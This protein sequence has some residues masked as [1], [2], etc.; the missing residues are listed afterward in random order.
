MSHYFQLYGLNKS[1]F[2]VNLRRELDKL[3]T[4]NNVDLSGWKHMDIN[5][6]AILDLWH[7][8][9]DKKLINDWYTFYERV[10][11]RKIIEFSGRETG[12]VIGQ[13]F[14]YYNR[15][16][17]WQ[18]DEKIKDLDCNYVLDKQN[19]VEIFEWIVSVVTLYD[20]EL[21]YTSGKFDNEA[22]IFYDNDYFDDSL[23]IAASQYG[24]DLLHYLET[25][26]ETN[27]EYYHWDN[28]F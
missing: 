17:G 1:S 14:E 19:L 25:I 12:M 7:F 5:V 24:L 8:L 13:L 21:K 16:F 27:Y 23:K 28:N 2:K 22:R 3:D 11:E 9:F 10:A 4:Q 26:R 18:E 6:E 20:P 15:G